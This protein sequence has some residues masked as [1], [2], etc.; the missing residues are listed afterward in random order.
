MEFRERRSVSLTEV[1]QQTGI[2]RSTINRIANIHGY[3]TTTDVLDK[4]C[5]YFKCELGEI[6][7]HIPD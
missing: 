6:A 7:Q 3:S 1:A 2:A 5:T 4:L